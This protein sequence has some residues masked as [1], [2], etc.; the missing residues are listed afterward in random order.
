[1]QLLS[2]QSFA[3]AANQSFGL[4]VGEAE[5]PVT[6]IEVKPLPVQPYPGMM[7]EPFSLLFRSESQ[8]VLPQRQYRLKNEQMG[9]LDIF[10]VPIARDAQGIIYQAVF[11]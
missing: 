1:M 5:M 10:L 3:G 11:N 4:S 8:I 6:L 2:I 7:R 9:A